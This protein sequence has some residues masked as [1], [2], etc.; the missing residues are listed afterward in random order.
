MCKTKPIKPM[1]YPI[2]KICKCN[3][4]TCNKDGIC[5]GCKKIN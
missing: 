2:Y 5:N 3:I 1:S 4:Q